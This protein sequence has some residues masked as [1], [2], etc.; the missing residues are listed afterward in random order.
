MKSSGDGA[1][2]ELE[3]N[4]M[5]IT[6]L[7][8]QCKPLHTI[9]MPGACKSGIF[10]SPSPPLSRRGHRSAA[11]TLNWEKLRGVLWMN[12]GTSCTTI[13]MLGPVFDHGN[14][15]PADSIRNGAFSK[16]LCGSP[17]E[18]GSFVL[19]LKLSVLHIHEDHVWCWFR[20]WY[21]P[22]YSI[23]NILSMGPSVHLYSTSAFGP[24]QK[25]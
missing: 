21:V 6:S 23:P 5:G 19:S 17:A 4:P 11:Q 15:L 22:K 25:R 1:G 8:D 7:Q 20:R 12:H 16:Q 24:D 18:N 10:R 3:I 2:G 14:E 9:T 13:A